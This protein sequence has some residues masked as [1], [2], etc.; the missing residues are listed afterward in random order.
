MTN[1]SIGIDI[2]TTS[3]TTSVW[4]TSDKVVVIPTEHGSFSMPSF[5]AFVDGRRLTGE[6]AKRE[7]VQH[8]T[9]TIYD[10][11]RLIGRRFSEPSFQRD[12]QA[13]PFKV[14]AKSGDIPHVQVVEDGITKEFAAEQLMAMLLG[15][16][17]ETAERFLGTEVR[18][19][20]ATVPA[21]YNYCQRASIISSGMIGGLNI[22]RIVNRATA[23]AVAYGA[24]K[25]IEKEK[26]E[27]KVLVFGIGGCSTEVSILAIE[28]GIFEVIST[29]GEYGVGAE[30]IDRILT[31]FFVGEVSKALGLDVSQD[32]RAVS[33]LRGFSEGVKETLSTSESVSFEIDNIVH[34]INFHGKISRAQFEHLC[35]DFFHNCIRPVGVA[36]RE[37]NLAREAIDEVYLFGGCS[38]IPRLQNVLSEYFGG[39]PLRESPR[40]EQAASCGAAIEAAIQSR[41]CESALLNRILLIDVLSHSVGV[42]VGG[43]TVQLIRKNTPIPTERSRVFTTLSHTDAGMTLM[44]FEGDHGSS[45]DNLY[46]GKIILEDI[47]PKPPKPASLQVTFSV[48]VSGT[49]RV[50]AKDLSTQISLRRV[51]SFEREALSIHQMLDILDEMSAHKKEES[52]HPEVTAPTADSRDN[53]TTF[54]FSDVNQDSKV[55]SRRQKADQLRNLLEKES[56]PSEV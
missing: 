31:R 4:N 24:E 42:D 5:V 10:I 18:S 1:I 3:C 55:A 13:W 41:A 16:I 2:G 29:T 34:N 52:H 25:K 14:V 21:Y 48:D 37:A 6:R 38:R 19:A 12:M 23:A 33:L 50:E 46:L 39:M 40:Q 35:G 9:N 51:L 11:H 45:K 27:K 54:I 43:V 36:L 30:D 20:V 44:V 22:R 8:P 53:I 28:N 56:R 26:A 49:I 15:E 7:R 47:I 32:A 17:K